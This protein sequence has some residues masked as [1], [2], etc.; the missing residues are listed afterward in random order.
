MGI[1][2][3]IGEEQL[4]LSMIGCSPEDLE[5]VLTR[6]RGARKAFEQAREA[7]P[8][9]DTAFGRR[10]RTMGEWRQHLL[11]SGFRQRAV[12][13]PDAEAVLS[14]ATQ[15]LEHRAGAAVALRALDPERG[16]ERI[17]VA[18]DVAADPRARELLLATLDDD[19]EVEEALERLER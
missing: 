18:A 12:T 16:P 6:L 14:D 11:D 4:I 5:R 9:V 1:R 8:R 2:V 3:G 7:A 17:R 10:G 15:P 19:V 13:A